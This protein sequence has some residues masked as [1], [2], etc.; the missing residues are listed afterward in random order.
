MDTPPP[1]PDAYDLTALIARL[2]AGWRRVLGLAL[3]AALLALGLAAL[4][5]NRYRAEALVAVAR[6]ASLSFDDRFVEPAPST[7]LPVRAGSLRTYPELARSDAVA[8]AVREALPERLDPGIPLEA[9]RRRVTVRALAEGT[10]I[11]IEASGA[12]P[13]DASALANAWA[14]ALTARVDALYGSGEDRAAVQAAR[15]AAREDLSAAAEALA[16]YDERGRLERLQAEVESLRAALAAEHAAMHRLRRLEADLEGL[17]A[18]LEAGG[19]PGMAIALAR[20]QLAALSAPRAGAGA[21]AGAMAAAESIELS[22]PAGAFEATVTRAELDA[23]SA[24]AE[25]ALLLLSVN[26]NETNDGLARTLAAQTRARAIRSALERAHGLA[27][28]RYLTLARKADELELAAAATRPELRLASPAQP[29]GQLPW[30]DWLRR[31]LAA[32]LLGVLAGIGWL[33][34]RPGARI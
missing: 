21:E 10:L 14:E 34:W 22:L 30:G 32:A 17:R 33:L 18:Q 4:G 11:G 25:T 19:A 3:T 15:E 9:L 24:G 26:S 2:R 23:L 27:D 6:P 16:Q 28:E 7:Q 5:P 31:A 13:E 8:L 1:S 29:S 20:L 12:S